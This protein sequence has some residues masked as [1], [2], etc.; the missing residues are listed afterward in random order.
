VDAAREIALRYTGALP[1]DKLTIQFTDLGQKEKYKLIAINGTPTTQSR[2]SL[3]G[4]ISGGEFG[5]ALLRVFH[6]SS[7]LISSGSGLS[8]IRQR[9]TAVYTY[10]PKSHHVLG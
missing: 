7:M 6:P 2:E 10:R 3:G 1:V 4:L 8:S 5:S 9:R